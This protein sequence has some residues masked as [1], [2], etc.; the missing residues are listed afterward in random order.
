MKLVRNVNDYNIGQSFYG[1]ERAG[2]I[3]GG[4]PG[5][6]VLTCGGEALEGMVTQVHL[7]CRIIFQPVDQNRNLIP[8]PVDDIF[9]TCNMLPVPAKLVRGMDIFSRPLWW[10]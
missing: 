7:H 5:P 2:I 10:L 9:P 4:V 8:L 6:C 3:G 1:G